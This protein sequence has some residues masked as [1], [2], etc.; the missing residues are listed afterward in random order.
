MYRNLESQRNIKN[1]DTE[2]WKLNM[3][4][5]VILSYVENKRL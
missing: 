4:C 5:N 3:Q 2:V 1:L